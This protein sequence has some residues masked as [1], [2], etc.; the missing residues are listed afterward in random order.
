[1]LGGGGAGRGR[2]SRVVAAVTTGRTWCGAVAYFVAGEPL[3]PLTLTVDMAIF[4]TPYSSDVL[5]S[6]CVC[7]YN[8]KEQD[9]S[10]EFWFLLCREALGEFE[11]GKVLVQLQYSNFGP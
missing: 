5:L 6:A 7:V 2:R 3:G 4:L 8:G 11:G 1:M 9:L 10:C